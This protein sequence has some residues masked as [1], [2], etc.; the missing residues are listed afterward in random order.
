M[1]LILTTKQYDLALKQCK[2]KFPVQFDG[3]IAPIVNKILKN[4]LS[5]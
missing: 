2:P 5:L 3:K 4:N 1:K